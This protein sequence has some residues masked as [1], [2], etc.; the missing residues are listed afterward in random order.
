M[1]IRD[2]LR[3]ASDSKNLLPYLTDLVYPR[4]V[5]LSSAAIAAVHEFGLEPYLDLKPDDLSYGRRRLVGIARA[6]A[7]QPSVLMLDEPAS[8]LDNFETGELGKLI[9][10][11]AR[12]WGIG[13]LLVEHDVPLVL[14]VCDTV[15][16]MQFGAV[17]AE[18]TPAEIS[19][20]RAV[21]EAYLGE[22]DTDAI[23]GGDTAEA[24][25]A[26]AMSSAVS[27]VRGNR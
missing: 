11:L 18:G 9:G 13:I 12:E 17:I 5:P 27:S 6:L 24:A 4:D 2:N 20:N 16:V 23:A 22:A 8:G 21:L 26:A 25:P 7:T 14:G 15:T 10:R 1:S 19:E 3:T